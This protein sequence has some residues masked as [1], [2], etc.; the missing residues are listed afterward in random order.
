[1]KKVIV[2]GILVL[3]IFSVSAN[4]IVSEGDEE[5][6]VFGQFLVH[7]PEVDDTDYGF[8]GGAG[9]GKFLTDNWQF[10]T[11]GLAS[12]SD[13]VD[14][15]SAGIN[16]KYHFT[17]KLYSSPYLGAHGNYGYADNS[18]SENGFYY[19]PIVGWRF[20]MEGCYDVFAEY[21]YNIYTG[22]IDDVVDDTH[23]FTIGICFD[24]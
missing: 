18:E 20:M 8:G 13:D 22:S 5:V 7:D 10:N 2:F 17:P 1:M 24:Y 6:F 19:G 15:Y 23:S 9:W 12:W 21:Q 3:A 4:A 16:F 14:L 11:L